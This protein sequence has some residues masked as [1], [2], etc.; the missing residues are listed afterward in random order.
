[1]KN[2][3]VVAIVYPLMNEC[4]ALAD[5]ILPV[6]SPETVE[7]SGGANGQKTREMQ[8]TRPR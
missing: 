2:P 3:F 1:M 4:A 6:L 7:S 8:D 5:Y